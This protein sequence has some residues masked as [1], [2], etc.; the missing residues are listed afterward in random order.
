MSKAQEMYSTLLEESLKVAHRPSARTRLVVGANDP[1]QRQS[2]LRKG[3]EPGT[4]ARPMTLEVH[5]WQSKPECQTIQLEQ[6]LLIFCSLYNKLA[7]LA[8]GTHGKNQG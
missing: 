6:V 4:E 2:G 3:T 1:C 8:L 5:E 7:T